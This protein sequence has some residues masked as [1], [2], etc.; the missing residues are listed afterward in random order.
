ML[1]IKMRYISKDIFKRCALNAQWV[2]YLFVKGSLILE[3][4]FL[5]A[6]KGGCVQGMRKELSGLLV[7]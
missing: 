1:C 2:F 5:Y 3:V 7:F 4:R 6:E